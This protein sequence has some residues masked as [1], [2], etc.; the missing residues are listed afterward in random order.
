MALLARAILCCIGVSALV[1][2]GMFAPSFWA[3]ASL[4]GLAAQIVRSEN[5]SAVPLEQALPVIE[6][7]E[8]SDAC[9]PQAMHDAAIIRGRLVQI[10]FDNSD[11]DAIRSSM[12]AANAM[13]RKS[14]S[15]APADA[16]MWFA[17]FWI[18]SMRFG[19]SERTIGYLE[20]SYELGPYEGWVA[21]KRNRYAL[22]AYKE[23]PPR[24]Q[25]R[26]VKEFAALVNSGFIVETTATLM[27]A[28]WPFHDTLLAGLAD[29]REKYKKQLATNLR[30][31]GVEV[32]VP[33]VTMPEWRPWQVD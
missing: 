1:W 11:P 24:L 17:L 13:I 29:T 8:R 7:L 10:A 3:C 2:A 28:G 27:G 19:L 21:L 30:R 9:R 12:A 25:A 26:M 33:G 31:A 15:C 20:K 32:A 5:S 16:F 4:N 18:E 22:L 6:A 23:L 14:L